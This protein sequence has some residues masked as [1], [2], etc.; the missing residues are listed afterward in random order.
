MK[1]TR[2]RATT[3]ETVYR[4]WATARDSEGGAVKWWRAMEGGSKVGAGMRAAVIVRR[5]REDEEGRGAEILRFG[6][7][8]GDALVGHDVGRA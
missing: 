1:R 7:C 5:A 3:T 6:N 4:R 8:A 2:D